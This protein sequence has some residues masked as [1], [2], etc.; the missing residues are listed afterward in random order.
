MLAEMQAE[1]T[2]HMLHWLYFY[3]FLLSNVGIG[4][5]INLLYFDLLELQSLLNIFKIVKDL[6]H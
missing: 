4:V 6:I 2:T 1:V 5:C 3:V